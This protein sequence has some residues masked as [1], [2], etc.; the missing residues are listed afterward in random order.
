MKSND[1]IRILAYEARRCHAA[2]CRRNEE[3]DARLAA[4]RSRVL[5]ELR[6]AIAAG[7]DRFLHTGGDGL[8]T[9]LPVSPEWTLENWLLRLDSNQQPSG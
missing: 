7:I 4:M 1:W 6:C 3:A 9:G 5:A 2:D 8:K